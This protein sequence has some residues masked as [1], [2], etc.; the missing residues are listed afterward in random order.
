[1]AMD[2]SSMA[3]R[4]IANIEARNTNLDVTN[5]TLLIPY[6]EDICDGVIEEIKAAMEIETN[7]PV[8]G[9]QT[10]SNTI[11]ATGQQTSIS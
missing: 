4:I 6:I 11:N 5:K 1:M 7:V 8:I 10:G 3:S 2:K 9:I